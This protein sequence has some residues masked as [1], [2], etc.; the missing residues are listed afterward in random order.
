MRRI[1]AQ[2]FFLLG[3][4]LILSGTLFAQTS[5]SPAYPYLRAGDR[6]FEQGKYQEALAEYEKALQVEPDNQYAQFQIQQIKE[7]TGVGLKPEPGFELLP[8]RDYSQIS[9][10]LGPYYKDPVNN[11]AIRYP[12][13]WLLDNSDESFTVKFIEPYSEAFLF[14]KVLPTPKPV[15]INYQFRD[16]VEELARNLLKQIPDSAL[17]YCSF[18]RFKNDTVLRVEIVFKAG[19]NRALIVT[20]LLSDIDRLIIIGWV[21]QEKLVPIFEP[22]LEKA[23]ASLKLTSS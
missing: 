20:R 7:K 3:L 13:E 16:R 21:C 14:I 6:F 18:E 17:R 2:R 8:F 19:K 12:K 10:E 9:Y 11:F 15:I 1:F 4:I 22:W 23:L 5:S